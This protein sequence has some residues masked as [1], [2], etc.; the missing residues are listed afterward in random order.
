MYHTIGQRQ[1]AQQGWLIV[2]RPLGT[3]WINGVSENTLIVAQGNEHPALFRQTLTASETIWISG[4]TPAFPLRCQKIRYRQADQPGT[5]ESGENQLTV[6]F[7]Q[8]QRA[9]TPAIG[10]VHHGPVCLGGGV[11]ERAQ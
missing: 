7:D 6:T 9:I 11:I 3:W 5:V 2:P 8:P 4:D 10:G 1:E